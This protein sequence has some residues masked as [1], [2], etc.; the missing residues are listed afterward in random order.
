MIYAPFK[1]SVGVDGQKT[2]R[3]GFNRISDRRDPMNLHIAS[4]RKSKRR[5]KTEYGQMSYESCNSLELNVEFLGLSC[6]C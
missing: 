1:C 2:V 6:R 5:G 3:N 4:R